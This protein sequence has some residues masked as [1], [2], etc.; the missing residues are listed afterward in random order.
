MKTIE[1]VKLITDTLAEYKALQITDLNVTTLTDIADHVIICSSISRRHAG[2]LADKII[3]RVKESDVRPLGIEGKATAEWILIDLCDIV[4]HIM[5][6]KIRNFYS[7]EQLWST[8]E[9]TYH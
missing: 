8:T 1:L 5:L 2:G 3:H 9:V 4:V 7:L 6:P